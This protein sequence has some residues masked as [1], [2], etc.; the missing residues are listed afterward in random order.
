[1]LSLRR[2]QL[3]DETMCIDYTVVPR[4]VRKSSFKCFYR[5][6]YDLFMFAY[7]M[8]SSLTLLGLISWVGPDLVLMALFR[9][10]LIFYL[11]NNICTAAFKDQYLSV[12]L[13][14]KN[15]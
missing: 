14:K 10:I 15:V 12:V 3:Y 7:L 6:Q 13:I 11:L 1:M 2:Y 9:L 4:D 5:D 8:I